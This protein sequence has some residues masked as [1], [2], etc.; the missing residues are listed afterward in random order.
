ME[1]GAH[2]GRRGRV[3]DVT[4]DSF[5]GLAPIWT[6]TIGACLLVVTL[7]G[8]HRLVTRG[9][10]RVTNGVVVTGLLIV[11]ILVIGTL[12]VSCTGPPSSNTQ[13]RSPGD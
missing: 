13:S 12:V 9:P 10:A 7:L 5:L 6:A 8:L 3:A 1:A 4:N 11:A 2:D